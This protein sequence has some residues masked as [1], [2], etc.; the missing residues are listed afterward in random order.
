M[1]KRHNSLLALCAILLSNVLN[2]QVTAPEADRKEFERIDK[3]KEPYELGTDAQAKNGVPKGSLE[4][5]TWTSN[6]IYPGTTRDYWVYVPK[7]YDPGSPACLVIFQDGDVYLDLSKW[8][9]GIAPTTVFDNLIHQGEIPV[10]IGLFLK[11]GDK[12]PGTPYK[13]GTSNRSFEYDAVTDLY[14]RFLLEE[15]MPGL[16]KQYNITH[17]PKGRILVGF[18]SGGICAFTAAWHRPDEFGNVISHCGSFTDMRGGHIY[19]PLIRRTPK[20]T[21]RV[22]LQS[23]AQDLNVIWGNWP[24]AN[25]AMASALEYAG[26]D[27]QFVFGEGTHTLR[28]GGQVFPATL[29]WIWRD[30]PKGDQE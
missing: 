15:M 22:F 5:Y 11:P 26:Y 1:K 28:H 3:I 8:S 21:I 25:Q 9:P 24:L 20:K 2:A 17:D 6:H 27:Y 14:S 23:G 4:K 13:G 18:S 16:M 29:R 10:T 19:P 7:Q 12:G 30:Y